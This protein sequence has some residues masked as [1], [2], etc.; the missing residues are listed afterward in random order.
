MLETVKWKIVVTNETTLA[1]I[2]S[3]TMCDM[4]K[5]IFSAEIGRYWDRVE[6]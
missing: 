2:N 6:I 1:S 5:L 3:G 4:V